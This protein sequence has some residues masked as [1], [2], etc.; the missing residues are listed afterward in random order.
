M[1]T[2]A[3]FIASSP[4]SAASGWFLG[5]SAA[6]LVGLENEISGG[7]ERNLQGATGSWKTTG[8][9]NVARVN[10]AATLL[11]NGQVLITGGEQHLVGW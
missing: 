6:P 5:I 7:V 11:T 8:S 10:A 3:V 4:S 2:D 9:M 1:T